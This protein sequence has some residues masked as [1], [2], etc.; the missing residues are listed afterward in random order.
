MTTTQITQSQIQLTPADTVV[1][2]STI[3]RNRYDNGVMIEPSSHLVERAGFDAKEGRVVLKCGYR[4][5]T[6]RPNDLV[7]VVAGATAPDPQLEDLVDMTLRGAGI[8][9]ETLTKADE[10]LDDVWHVG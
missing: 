8:T 2:G 3:I 10:N 9:E 4:V 7:M 1:A 6:L 5:F